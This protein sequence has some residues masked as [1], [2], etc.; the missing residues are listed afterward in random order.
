MEGHSL[1]KDKGVGVDRRAPSAGGPRYCKGMNLT[2]RSPVCQRDPDSTIP[3]INFNKILFA[4][5]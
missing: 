4:T 1:Q 5:F 2:D 3:E